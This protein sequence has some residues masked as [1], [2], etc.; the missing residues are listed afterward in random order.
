MKTE[1]REKIVYICNGL[2]PECAGRP[3]CMDPMR[4]HRTTNMEYAAHQNVVML[5][6]GY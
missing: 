1:A 5:I 4:C 3:Y 2:V 6:K